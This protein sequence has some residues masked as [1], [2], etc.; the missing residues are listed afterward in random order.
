MLCSVCVCV[1]TGETTKDWNDIRK[2]IRKDD[3]ISTVVNFDPESIS[4]KQARPLAHQP[5]LAL[6]SPQF[7][8]VALQAE[9]PGRECCG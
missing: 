8:F 4:P 5:P 9:E 3:F 2:L 6:A 1:C 7:S